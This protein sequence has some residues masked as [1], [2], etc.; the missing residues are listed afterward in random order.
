PRT[1]QAFEIDRE[2][3]PVRERYGEGKF[4][5]SLLLARRLVEAGVALVTVNYDDETRGEKVSPFWDTHTHNFP[6]LRDRLAPRFD[7]APPPTSP[8]RSSATSASTP[9]AR[10]GTSS[11]RSPA[12]SPRGRRCGTWGKSG[13]RTPDARG[14]GQAEPST[15]SMR[16]T[17][18]F[19]SS[20]SP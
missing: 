12:S 17:T 4:A 6:A 19:N 7:R 10:T 3:R 2:P 15:L 5:Q 9:P 11:S 16:R 13:A 14:R 20:R 18:S 8:R 1:V